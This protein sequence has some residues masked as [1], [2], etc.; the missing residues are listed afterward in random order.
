M[1]SLLLGLVLLAAC[2]GGDSD[3]HTL[4][5]CEG[6][7]DNQGNPFT[8][9]CEAACS[10]PPPVTAETCDTVARLN[11]ALFDFDG[12]DGCCVQDGDTIRFYDCQ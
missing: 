10:K 11:C 2:G 9:M 6:W 12:T 7:T 1:K 4:G 8:G 3:P 5:T